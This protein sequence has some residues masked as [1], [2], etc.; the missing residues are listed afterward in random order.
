M[1]AGT[2]GGDGCLVTPLESVWRICWSLMRSQRKGFVPDHPDNTTGEQQSRERAGSSAAEAGKD[3]GP[4]G[5]LISF[6]HFC[7]SQL[8]ADPDPN[9]KSGSEL[10][11]RLLKVFFLFP[12]RIF[13]LPSA[14]TWPQQG[15]W[16]TVV[17]RGWNHPATV[18]WLP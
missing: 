12:L 13:P 17:P 9:V 15:A 6:S 18:V 2:R 5:A 10:L 7:C 1:A 4:A 8:A 14:G 16:D 11:D 3:L